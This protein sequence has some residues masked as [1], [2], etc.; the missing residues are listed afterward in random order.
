MSDNGPKKRRTPEPPL[1]DF[2]LAGPAAWGE[3]PPVDRREAARRIRARSAG[4]EPARR[5]PAATGGDQPSDKAKN[6]KKRPPKI[7]RSKGLFWRLVTGLFWLGL[8]LTIAGLT[9]AFIGYNYLAQDLPPTDGLKNY[10]PPIVTYFYS[11]D[12]QVIGEYSHERRFVVPLSEIS[13]KLKEAFLA[14]EDAQFYNHSGINYKALIRAFLANLE[15][16]G[17]S[18]GGSTITQQVVKTF[19]LTP[20]RSYIRKLKEIILAFRIEK[21]LTKDQILHLYLN[22]IYL[23]KG[24]HGVEAAARTYFAKS[25]A[26]LSI[27]EAAMLAGLT[28]SPNENPLTRPEEARRKQLSGIGR[29]VTVGYI[30]EAEAKAARAEK[31]VL[32]K[33][34]PNPNTS[35]TPYFTEHVRR[36]MEGIFGADSLYNEGWKV[37]TTVNI[38]AQHAADRAVAQGLWE[39]ARRRGYSGHIDHLDTDEKIKNFLA[40]EAKNLPPEGLKS[41]QLYKAAV[42]EVDAKNA[43]LTVQVGPHI[44]RVVKKNLSWALKNKATVEKS[45]KKGDLVWVRLAVA[46]KAKEDNSTNSF[47]FLDMILER[48]TDVQS[49]LLSMDLAN[50][51]IKAMVGGRDFSES[52]FNRAVQ[53]QRQPGSSFKPILYASALDNGFTPGSIMLDAPL[54][55]DDRGSGRRW[56]PVNSDMQFKGPMTIYTALVGS[57]NLISIKLLDRIGYEALE[58]TAADLGITEKLP[59]TLTIALGAHGLHIPELVT[60]YS[61][62]ANMGERVE[63]RYITRIED[64]DGNI[65]LTFEPKRVQALDPGTACAINWMLQGVVNQGTGTAAKPLGRPVAGKT[66]TTNDYSDAWFIGFTPELVTAVWVGTDQQKPRAVGEVGGRVAGPIFLYY[67][68]EALKD[69]EIV[70]FEVPPE[71]E[72]VQ[73]GGLGVCYKAGTLGTGLSETITESS[74]E[75]TFLRGDFESATTHG[76]NGESFGWEGDLSSGQE[77]YNYTAPADDRPPAG[78]EEPFPMSEYA[79]DEIAEEPLTV[80]QTPPAAIFQPQQPAEESAPS[81]ATSTRPPVPGRLLTVEDTIAPPPAQAAPVVSAP[82]VAPAPSGNGRLPLYGGENNQSLPRY[83]GEGLSGNRDPG[84]QVRSYDGRTYSEQYYQNE[85]APSEIYDPAVFDENDYLRG[86]SG[87]NR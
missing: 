41:H 74:P 1:L 85:A 34:W 21:N 33:E 82:A 16:D 19:F 58:K 6:T 70:K 32:Q 67:M 26:D 80:P 35:V 45:F 23:G 38:E 62:F 83:S 43:A 44:G 50:G 42:I 48:N 12:G 78:F 81:A 75:E 73:D 68:R 66:G 49:A 22:Q 2:D 55:I 60:A 15:A 46:E 7:R 10:R 3:E 51:D 76:A 31:L 36:M 63:P 77:G 5:K 79:D 18:Q 37:Y 29:M 4:S 13:P 69:R 53:S 54:V 39:Y 61:A 9:V 25:C 40:E 64:R 8:A 56:K 47:E 84:G 71:A 11:D 52:Q 17:I 14:V 27:A 30:T 72:M 87:G 65:V 59:R 28:R 86:N 20:E 24:A 57:R